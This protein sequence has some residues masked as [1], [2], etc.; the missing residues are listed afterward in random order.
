[1]FSSGLFV[2]EKSEKHCGA[3]YSYF[4]EKS[5]TFSFLYPE[6][7][8]YFVS[9]IKFLNHIQ[10][11]EKYSSYA[12]QSSDWLIQIYEKYGSIIQ[13]ISDDSP[14]SNTSYSFDSAICAKGLLDYYEISKDVNYLNYAKK[15]L[16]NLR[17]EYLESDGSLI[18]CKDIGTNTPDE[19]SQ[20]WYKRK[21]CFHIKAAIPF[22]QINQYLDN[23][24]FLKIGNNICN[25]ISNF[26][27][28]NGSI[29]LHIDSDI[30]NLHTFCYALEGL[31]YGYNVTNNDK[32]LENIQKATDWCSKQISEDGSI[33]LWHNSKLKSK[34]AYS[35]A[36]L[37]RILILIDKVNVKAK[38]Q[39]EI[40]H[41]YNF[42]NTFQ[43]SDTSEKINGGFYEELYKSLFG[44]KK[45]LRVNSWTSMFALQSIYWYH[46]QQ[47]LRFNEQV[48]F[49]Y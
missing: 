9:T 31:I 43:A 35:I 37:I 1:M 23:D 39:S 2:S 6:I 47:N 12:K 17:D 20:V 27:N 3:V 28:S 30:I 19:S 26:Q 5:N 11:N 42:L 8:G 45:R 40:N 10:R 18:P 38:Y 25:N 7:T 21:G 13:G 22:F 46:N 16:F 34:A 32:Y 36:Q 49:L 48:N 4:D 15:I 33:D 24:D 41:L 44:W 29:R 14:T